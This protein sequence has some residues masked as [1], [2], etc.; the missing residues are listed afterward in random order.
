MGSSDSEA[1]VPNH[2]LILMIFKVSDI[3]HIILGFSYNRY[4]I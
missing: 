4:K 1:H 2:C 3:F